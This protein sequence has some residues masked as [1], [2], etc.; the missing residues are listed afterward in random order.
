M[1]ERAGES[2]FPEIDQAE[3]N[4]KK[5][6]LARYKEDKTTKLMCQQIEMDGL[7]AEQASRLREFEERMRA[8]FTKAIAD[9][10]FSQKSDL[11]AM[12]DRHK[13]ALE[14]VESNC[15]ASTMTM[16][17]KYDRKRRAVILKDGNITPLDHPRPRTH[18]QS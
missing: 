12:Q 5:T 8:K 4:H 10:K 14:G 18:A 7:Q 15:T 17:R 9:F 11:E 13:Y 1:S 2:K 16:S 3:R 6:F